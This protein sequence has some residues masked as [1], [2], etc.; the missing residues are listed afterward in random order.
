[1]DSSSSPDEVVG[2]TNPSI[3][4]PTDER[5]TTDL[6]S[7]DEQ[8]EDDYESYEDEN[9]QEQE[10]D[11]DKDEGGE[12]VEDEDS[13]VPSVTEEGKEGEEG[14]DSTTTSTTISTEV[15]SAETDAFET[16]NEDGED[17]T[18]TATSTLAGLESTL[19][20]MNEASTKNT[21]PTTSRPCFDKINPNTGRSDCPFRRN[22]C[23]ESRY[24]QLMR[25]QCPRTCGFCG[26]RRVQKA[27]PDR[28]MQ[29]LDQPSN[30]TFR[31]PESSAAL[32]EQCLSKIDDGAVSSHLWILQ[33]K[34][35][36]G[37]T[38]SKGLCGFVT[39]RRVSY[40]AKILPGQ[41]H[42][43]KAANGSTIGGPALK[44]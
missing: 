35:Y 19:T 5:S 41:R 10:D 36:Q 34:I 26:L 40:Q 13:T 37:H 11:R 18:P 15:S 14:K 30:R 24:I 16:T 6:T 4:I 32:Q 27:E 43:Y 2:R 20:T 7:I 1:S 23:M 38:D 12:E 9:E 31:L 3:L 39:K 44:G 28:C 42:T 22:L 29:R 33:Y 17:T 8:D 21:P 25:E